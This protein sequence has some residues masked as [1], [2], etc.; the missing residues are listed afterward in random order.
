MRHWIDIGSSPPG[1]PCAQVGTDDYFVRA[2]RECKAYIALLRRALGPEPPGAA[3][4]VHANPHDFGTYLSVV[5]FYEPDQDIAID[6]AFRCESE[7]PEFW[8]EEAR[9]ELIRSKRR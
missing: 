1:E 9:S 3:L 4:A 5:C 7:G 2:R 8:D 6:Y